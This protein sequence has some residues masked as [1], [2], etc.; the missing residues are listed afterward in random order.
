MS[1]MCSFRFTKNLEKIRLFL[2]EELTKCISVALAVALS[3][4]TLKHFIGNDAI[5]KSNYRD[6]RY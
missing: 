4:Y 2:S 1:Y 3:V 5:L 6:E